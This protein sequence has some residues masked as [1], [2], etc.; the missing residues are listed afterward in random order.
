MTSLRGRRVEQAK[1]ALISRRSRTRAQGSVRGQG[2]SAEGLPA[3]PGQLDP[4]A[5]RS[6]LVADGAG[7]G[8]Q[9]IANPRINDEAISAFQEKRSIDPNTTIFSPIAARRAAQGRPG[10]Y[11]NSAPAIRFS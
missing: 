2:R 1:S 5:E 7:G 10:Q 11:V 4:G 3:D 8:A 9:Q 6:A